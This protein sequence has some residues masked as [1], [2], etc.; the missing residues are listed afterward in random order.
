MSKAAKM[1]MI[2]DIRKRIG[3]SKDFMLVDASRVDANTSNVWRIGL[4]KKEIKAFTVK[5][6]LARI[7]LHEAGITS[8]DPYLEGPTTLI[9]GGEDVVALAKE[10]V[11][12]AKE[13]EALEVKGGTVDG[14]ESL[15]ADGVVSLSKSPGRE[16]LLSMIAGALL[17]PGSELAGAL[18]GPGSELAGALK[19]I[20][21]EEGE[22]ETE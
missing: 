4:Q 14:S 16:E 11:G 8:L 10:V 15:D 6:S 5:N 12:N 20:A 22:E 3:D 21:D 13:I 7:A 18:L 17:G 19:S 2:Q 9:W 1:A